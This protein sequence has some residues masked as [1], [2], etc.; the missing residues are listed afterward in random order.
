MKF[1]L[2][3][4]ERYQ[5]ILTYLRVE[6]CIHY[7]AYLSEPEPDPYFEQMLENLTVSEGMSASFECQVFPAKAKVTWLVDNVV[8]AVQNEI[9][10]EYDGLYRATADEQTGERRLTFIRATRKDA[11]CRVTATVGELMSHAELL[12]E[13]QYTWHS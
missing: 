12:V 11:G 1:C 6:E 9:D 13:G 10:P 2:R 7:N 4:I 8:V 3:N 5:S